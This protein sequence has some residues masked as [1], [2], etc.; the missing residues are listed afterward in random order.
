MWL[1]HRLI[2]RGSKERG[3][4]R[5]EVRLH[6]TYGD[7]NG[8]SKKGLAAWQVR[9]LGPSHPMTNIP[10]AFKLLL[11][12]KKLGMKEGTGDFSNDSCWVLVFWAA[13]LL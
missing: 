10:L 8:A 5:D 9:S 4:K 6:P 12:G 1:L 13:K 11:W 2:W 3:R 7:H